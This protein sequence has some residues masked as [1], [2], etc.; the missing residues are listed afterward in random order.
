V[1]VVVE[2]KKRIMR[3]GNEDI[4][5]SER[6]VLVWWKFKEDKVV[7]VCESESENSECV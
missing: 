7:D 5:V 3:D 6:I 4:F 1:S 2:M